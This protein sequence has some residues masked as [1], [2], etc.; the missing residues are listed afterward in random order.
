MADTP[1]ICIVSKHSK[2]GKTTFME[3][4]IKELIGRGYKVGAVKNDFHGFQIDVPGKDTWKF[5]Q[6]GAAATAIIGPN[7]FALIQQTSEKKELEDVIEMIEGVDI[8]LVEGYKKSY[9]PRIEI[10][11]KE[12][13]TDIISSPQNLLAV[14][15]DVEGLFVT[16]GITVIDI[17]DIKGAAD[18]I[19]KLIPFHIRRNYENKV[20][21]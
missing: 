21:C 13:G 17:N 10:V 4:L 20:K 16:D 9:K 1:V 7:R 5:S 3:K 6:A 14:A 18:L 8:I 15:T 12:K 11:R 19:E 2:T